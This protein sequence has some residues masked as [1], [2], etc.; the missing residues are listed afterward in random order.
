M[1]DLA[2]NYS[3]FKK[4]DFANR[5]ISVSFLFR[6]LI[7]MCILMFIYVLLLYLP[8]FELLEKGEV[9]EVPTETPLSE[10]QAWLYM[11]DVLLGVEY[12]EYWRLDWIFCS[13]LAIMTFTDVL[14]LVN[15]IDLLF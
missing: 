5:K 9:M 15:G 2:P 11:R 1:I 3:M 12:R 13:I 7:Y 14:K 8:V 10:E 6:E 4:N